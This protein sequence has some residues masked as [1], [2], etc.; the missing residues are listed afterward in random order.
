M[1]DSLG[2]TEQ[3]MPD[4]DFSKLTRFFG[5]I[6][7]GY[8]RDVEYHNDLHGTDVAQMMLIFLKKGGLQQL[9]NLNQLDLLSIVIG[10]VCHDFAHDGFNNAYHVNSISKR[11]IRYNDV[12]VQEN[13]HVAETCLILSQSNC[14]FLTKYSRDEFRAFR[15]RL[16]GMILATDMA[17]HVSDLSSFKSL[18]EQRSIKAGENSEK[19]I[20]YSNA[21]KEFDS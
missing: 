6:Y 19:I 13:Y 3:T 16:V 1:I 21:T 9:A 14:N 17:R 18:L 5:K 15:K 2:L 12:A 8:R 20:D 10:S 11:A 7:Q 4:L